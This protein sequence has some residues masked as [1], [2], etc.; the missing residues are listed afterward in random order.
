MRGVDTMLCIFTFLPEND[1]KYLVSVRTTAKENIRADI[2]D[3]IQKCCI[4]KMQMFKL[5]FQ[6]YICMLYYAMPSY[7]IA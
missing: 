5:S 4:G 2:F 3:S 7:S 1:P 6:G